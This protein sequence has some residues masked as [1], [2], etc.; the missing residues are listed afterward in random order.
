MSQLSDLSAMSNNLDNSDNVSSIGKPAEIIISQ[1]G[2]PKININGFLFVKDKNREDIFYWICERKNFKESRCTARAVT[3]FLNG[4]HIIKK[5][6][7]HSHN[8]A[9]EA[10]KPFILEAKNKIKALS[11]QSNDRPVQIINAVKSSVAQDI[12][13]CFPNDDVL[14]R[15]INRAKH[16]DTPV[17]P[18][19]LGNFTLPVQY[20][21]TLSGQPF[22]KDIKEGDERIFLFTTGENLK[23]LHSSKF[24]I[25]DGTFKTVPTIFRQMYTIHANIGSASNV[26]LVP[27]VYALMSSKA[28]ELYKSLF[29]NVVDWAEDFGYQLKPEFILTDFEKGTIN[30]VNAIIPNAQSK[31]CH[32]HLSQAVYRQI[33]KNGLSTKYGTDQNFSL[34]IRHIPA[35]AFLSPLEIPSSFDTLRSLM[36]REAEP[37]LTWFEENFVRGKIR[38]TGQ[39]QR[40]P[41]LFPPEVWSVFE[42]TAFSFPRTQNN[43]EAWH[44]RWETL[45]GR[46][47]VGIFTIIKEIQKEQSRVENEIE[48]AIRGE[49]AKKRRKEDENRE[50]RIQNIIDN[51]NNR[52]VLEFLRGIAHN[53]SF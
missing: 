26:R 19:Q 13:P 17:E 32:F 33:Q 6:D 30:A 31:G 9:A 25:M 49:P 35:L 5:F 27:L 16:T 20:A 39:S 40:S 42:N 24:W 52:T 11:K 15:Q 7:P 8:H 38:R 51:R 28:E 18:K 43:V 14:R 48:R 23:Q 41:P 3:T 46:S 2:Q 10:S 4:E 47:H 21:V 36:P 22:F 44:R 50:K 34:L 45:I 53:V 37:V 29:Q 1:K 12:Q